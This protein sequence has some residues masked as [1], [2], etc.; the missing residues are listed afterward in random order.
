[1]ERIK[2]DDKVLHTPSQEQWIVCGVDYERG[3]LVPCGYPF[4]TMADIKD[5]VLV[6]SGRGRQSEAMRKALQSVG[7]SSFLGGGVDARNIF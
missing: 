6:E 3:K 4:P 1:M 7:L 5:C 2:P